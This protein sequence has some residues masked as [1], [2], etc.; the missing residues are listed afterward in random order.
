MSGDTELALSRSSIHYGSCAYLGI[1]GFEAAEV[2]TPEYDLVES[3]WP[4]RAEGRH[5]RSE[6]RARALP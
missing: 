2:N 6:G 4:G 1:S 5:R 3:Q